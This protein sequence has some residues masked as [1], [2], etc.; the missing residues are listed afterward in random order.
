MMN[1]QQ[2]K[3]WG[4]WG[5][6]CVLLVGYI[7]LVVWRLVS[8][9]PELTIYLQ[10]HTWPQ[11]KLES[12]YVSSRTCKACHTSEHASWH[13]SF[14]RTMTQV[15]TRDT[16]LG[17][18]DHQALELDGI[19]YELEDRDDGFWVRIVRLEGVEE[20][21][22]VLTTGSH[23]MQVVWFSTGEQRELASLPFVYLI[24]DQRWVPRRSA[25]LRPPAQFHDTEVGRWNQDC[26]Q[27]HA[28]RSRPRIDPKGLAK[29]DT[30]VGE[31]GIACEA[32]HGPA[33]DHVALYRSPITRYLAR[34][35]DSPGE[36]IV[37]P[38]KLSAP[39]STMVCGQCHGIHLFKSQP[40]A[41]KWFEHGFTYR[42]GE[43]EHD[44]FP[45]RP[46]SRDPRLTSGLQSRPTFLQD[47]F[48]SDGMVRVSGREYNGLLES[49][50]FKGGEFSCLSCHTM[51]PK[52]GSDL[53]IW[54]DDQLKPGMRGNE[55][56]LSCH[57]DLREGL[58]A[59]THHAPSSSGSLCYNCHM[60]HTTYGLLKG[61]RSHQ[62]SS[63]SILTTQ[64]TGR[65]ISCNQCHLD[66]TLAWTSHFL[67]EWYKTPVPALSTDE[68]GIAAALLWTL[69]GDAGQRALMAWS[70]GWADAREASGTSW[71][72]PYLAQLLADPYD[73]V[74]LIAQ[75][76]AAT[77]P[78]ISTSAYD[79]LAPKSVRN[80]AAR[81]IVLQWMKREDQQQRAGL[82]RLLFDAKGNFRQREVDRLL[83]MRDDTPMNL[84]E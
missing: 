16:V 11:A 32:C 50:C 49:P 63:P 68:K 76:S 66:Q 10:R 20:Y 24:A 60:P 26:L 84:K 43:E 35:S 54:R 82:K 71:M 42:P 9:D 65:P 45:I 38:A 1:R 48:W 58:T 47:R 19:R 34:L 83:K 14:H 29:A 23:H 25:F 6:G 33:K 80:D 69:R 12:D 40:D 64:Q 79:F 30:E 39:E 73:A 36:N 52:D 74:R 57:E 31:F 5:I 53:E 41:L 46:T 56:C 4:V 3:A 8:P 7:A 27:C 81:G 13:L 22:I 18:F 21:P 77:L 44:R 70:M 61:I 75:R 28:T 17:P 78:G 67:A 37:N 55:S 51:H 15:A 2:Q 72:A 62:I 59:H